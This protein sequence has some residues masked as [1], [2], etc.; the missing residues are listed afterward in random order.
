MITL[1]LKER[2]YNGFLPIIKLVFDQVKFNGSSFKDVQREVLERN[3]HVFFLTLFDPNTK[4]LLLVKQ[5]RSGAIV[6]NQDKPFTIEPI[7]GMVDKG[8]TPIAAAIREAKEEA[9]IDLVEGDLELLKSCYMSPGISNE[10]AHFYFAKFDSSTYKT[11]AFGEDCESED[12]Q[13]M[14]VPLEE[15]HTLE[16]HFSVAT[17]VSGLSSHFYLLK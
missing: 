12:I 8:E 5:I 1:N 17:L 16:E 13:T 2:V 4:Q 6:D 11:G 15:L 7:A 10:Y 9:D 3:T 14:L